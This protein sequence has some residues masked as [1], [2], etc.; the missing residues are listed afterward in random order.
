MSLKPGW[1]TLFDGDDV[2]LLVN[3]RAERA[4]IGFGFLRSEG[5]K[6]SIAYDFIVE[7]L[8]C[9]HIH[10]RAKWNHWY[11]TPE[12]D[13]LK[14]LIAPYSPALAFGASMG[15]CAALRY[16]RALGA[17]K[18]VAGAPQ[19]TIDPASPPFDT[20][21]AEEAK[22]IRFDKPFPALSSTLVAYDPADALDAAHASI[23]AEH[24]AELLEV[25]ESGHAPL[26]QLVIREQ[27]PDI[28]RSMLK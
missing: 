14:P 23:C 26:D 15:G 6:P 3:R 21:W 24:G 8:G 18:I 28:L 5:G 19:V 1:V 12:M 4:L 22:A 13:L 11:Q 2:A 16:G 27:F 25:P 9:T 20:R 7:A 17:D 10:V